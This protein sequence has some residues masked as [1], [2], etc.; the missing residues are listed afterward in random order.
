MCDIYLT[1]CF[2]KRLKRL[3]CLILSFTLL[4]E[5]LSSD[6]KSI[7]LLKF[8]PFASSNC[9]VVFFPP[10]RFTQK[11]HFFAGH[12]RAH[13]ST[14]TC[15]ICL[16]RGTGGTSRGRTTWAPPVTSTSLSTAARAGQWEPPAL[17]QVR[18][19]D[20][21]QVTWLE[22]SCTHI[23]RRLLLVVR[24]IVQERCCRVH[25]KSNLWPT[26]WSSR[27]DSFRAAAAVYFGHQ[28]ICRIFYIAFI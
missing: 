19:R 23:V 25:S 10:R 21:L 20:R 6:Q 11:L 18:S 2:F 1:F 3:T 9:W 26:D 14:W 16:R 12:V 8:S 22:K 7:W 28:I 24:L 13:T 4:H 5:F 17:W 27:R 15:Q